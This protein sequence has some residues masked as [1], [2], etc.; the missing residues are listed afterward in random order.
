[1]SILTGIDTTAGGKIPVCGRFGGI[2]GFKI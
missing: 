1:M 2:D